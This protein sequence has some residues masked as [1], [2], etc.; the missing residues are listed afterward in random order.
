[1][2]KGYFEMFPEGVFI[3]WN[4]SKK[5]DRLSWLPEILDK[6]KAWIKDRSGERADLQGEDLS[7]A[8]YLL[9]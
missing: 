9:L 8:T 5:Q 1:M 4:F 7:D 2:D 6:H 3:N